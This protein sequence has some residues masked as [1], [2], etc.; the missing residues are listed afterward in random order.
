MGM[1]SRQRSLRALSDL[2]PTVKLEVEREGRDHHGE[3]LDPV[4]RFEP[5]I[6]PDEIRAIPHPTGVAFYGARP[7]RLEIPHVLGR[8]SEVRRPVEACREVWLR[9][10]A[11]HRALRASPCSRGG[12]DA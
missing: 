1:V 5:A 9:W 2:S 10:V 12:G 8:G 6:T 11:A 4:V 3:E 7:M